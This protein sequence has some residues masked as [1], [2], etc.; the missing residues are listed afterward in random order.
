MIFIIIL[1]LLK[2]TFHPDNFLE[3]AMI[4]HKQQYLESVK[5]LRAEREKG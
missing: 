1:Y 5:D 2:F 4:A 3:N